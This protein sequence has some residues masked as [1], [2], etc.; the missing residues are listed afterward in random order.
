MAYQLRKLVVNTLLDSNFEHMLR[1]AYTRLAPTKSN[2]YD[3]QMTK[4]MARVLNSN[5]NCVDVG[6]YRGEVLREMIRLSP[7]GK[8]FAF[9]PIPK[10]FQYLAE[11]FKTASVC[12]LALSDYSGEAEFQHV[13]GRTARSGF[14][15]V[16]YPDKNQE[17][18][19]IKVKVDCLDNVIPATIRVDFLKIDVEGAELSVLRG[20]RSLI[21]NS[22]P[23]IVFEHGWKRAATCDTTPEQIYDLLTREYGLRVSLMERWLK[24]QKPFSGDEFFRH[25]Y[26]DLDFCFVA[27]AS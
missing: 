27:Y 23:M 12:E 18:K 2:K 7:F 21:R 17:V 15:R 11:T 8:H 10:N 14:R 26:K 9:E 3:R 13:V 25:V 19:Q 1:K 16:D 22:Q 24:G 6:C 20:G 4:L 5:S